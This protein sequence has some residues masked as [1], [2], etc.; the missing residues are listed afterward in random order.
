MQAILEFSQLVTW[1]IAREDLPASLELTCA[2]VDNHQL[3]TQSKFM[4]IIKVN[5]HK[6][7]QL[8]LISDLTDTGNI[9]LVQFVGDTK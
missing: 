5:Y 3:I 8:K 4:S 6:R 9:F 2:C 1:N 7:R